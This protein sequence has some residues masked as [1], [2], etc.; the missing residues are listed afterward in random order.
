[1]AADLCEVPRNKKAEHELVEDTM[2]S[3][4]RVGIMKKYCGKC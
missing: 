1:M 4:R 3:M 2:I